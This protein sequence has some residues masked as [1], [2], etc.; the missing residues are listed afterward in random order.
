MQFGVGKSLTTVDHSGASIGRESISVSNLD[1]AI[2]FEIL[3]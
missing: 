3:G 2:D 1:P